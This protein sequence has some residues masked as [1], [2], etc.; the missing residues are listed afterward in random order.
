MLLKSCSFSS[1]SALAGGGGI[2]SHSS[3]LLLFNVTLDSNEASVGSGG[4]LFGSSC[5]RDR[6]T[7]WIDVIQSSFTSNSAN[8]AGGALTLESCD[9]S[10]ADVSMSSNEAGGAGGG[11]YAGL[12]IA[13]M[14]QPGSYAFKSAGIRMS[15]NRARGGSGGGLAAVGV[16]V[17]LEGASESGGRSSWKD[18]TA[19]G[20]G[21]AISV[22]GGGILSISENSMEGNVAGGS[23]GAVSGWLLAEGANDDSTA[24]PLIHPHSHLPRISRVSSYFRSMHQASSC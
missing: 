19:E 18:N 4:A 14:G 6:G 20:D 11:A 5:S 2:F 13:D 21:G 10:L 9:V 24:A 1:N 22:G 17:S 3:Q 15:G 8:G 16:N 12:N 23:G 7:G